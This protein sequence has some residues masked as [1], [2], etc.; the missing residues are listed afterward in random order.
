MPRL[1]VTRASATGAVDAAAAAAPVAA[2]DPYFAQ[3]RLLLHMNGSNGSTT[4]TDSSASGLVPTV[5]GNAQISTTQSK[6]GGAS[7]AFD[8]AG[9]YLYYT[10]TN[11]GF[12]S[13]DFTIEC[14]IYL[15]ELK[16]QA[17]YDTSTLND[18]NSGQRT[19]GFVWYIQADGKLQLYSAQNNRGASTTT[20][21]IGQWYHLALTR[22]GSTWKYWINGQQDA[23]AI[24]HNVTITSTKVSIGLVANSPT[25]YLNGYIDELRVTAALRY[26]TNFSVPTAAFP[27]TAD[28]NTAWTPANVGTTAWFDAADATTITLNGSTVSQWADKSGNAANIAQATASQQ[29][30]Y[31]A[32]GLNSKGLLTFDGSNDYLY[33]DAIPLRGAT[34]TTFIAVY[35]Y[36]TGGGSEDLVLGLG[37]TTDSQRIRSL[38]R[39]A[40]GTTQGYAGWG[41]ELTSSS[42]DCDIGG[43]HHIW[44]AVQSSQTAPQLSMWRDGTIDS[45]APRSLSGTLSP[46]TTDG[47]TIGSL[48]GGSVSNYYSNVSVAEVL[49]FYRAV[50][51]DTRQKCEGYLAH[52][53]GLTA[54]LP[55]DHPYKAAPPYLP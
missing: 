42:L 34:L 22:T 28:A 25:Y 9:D 44:S 19:N 18:N 14:W 43:T 38:Y 54:S 32:N 48:K 40:N 53:W 31:S 2:T 21:N 20:L 26:T 47:F 50:S 39:S 29:P 45:G 16:D 24:T 3:T 46:T 36:I 15:N 41:A 1:R 49:V 6:F 13:G 30:S 10:E 33:S 23:T 52:K 17:I 4:F 7:A 37:Q 55:S 8:G 35:R 51:A 11:T 27:D 5:Y 12:G